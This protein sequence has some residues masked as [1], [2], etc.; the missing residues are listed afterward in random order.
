MQFKLTP[1]LVCFFAV[2][3]TISIANAEIVFVKQNSAPKYF[4]R[5]SDQ[6]GLCDGVYNHIQLRMQKAGHEVRIDPELYPIKRV[7]AMLE[8]GA[9]HVFCGAGRNK[10][11]EQK[12][13]YSKLPV[14]AVSNVLLMHE[15]DT[16]VASNYQDLQDNSL[17]IGAY[18]GTSSA[19]FLKKFEGVRVV[20][21]LKTLNE[22]MLS[23]AQK[24]IPYFYYHDLGL[25]YLVEVSDLPIKLMPTKFRTVDQWLLYSKSLSSVQIDALESALRE[26][27]DEGLLASIQSRYF[28]Y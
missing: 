26:I 22:A 23:V 9:G 6:S 12:Y 17:I 15:E 7:L 3:C 18:F 13:V 11:R 5:G 20:D 28:S 16:Y 10:E 14:Y 19:R 4:E 2:L 25:N 21:N 8:Q 24:T 27:T 1:V